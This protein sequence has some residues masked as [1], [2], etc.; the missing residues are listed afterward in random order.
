MARLSLRLFKM[1]IMVN[2]KAAVSIEKSALETSYILQYN[3][4][5][6]HCGHYYH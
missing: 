1:M 3:T 2:I 6:M 4:H 5:Y